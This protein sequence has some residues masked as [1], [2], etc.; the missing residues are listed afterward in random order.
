MTFTQARKE[1]AKLC[2]GKYR[3]MSYSLTEH[4]NGET[5]QQCRLYVHPSISTEYHATWQEALDEMR[6]LVDP[7]SKPEPEITAPK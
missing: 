7:V 1:F 5:E 6:K 4:A 2:P 3:D